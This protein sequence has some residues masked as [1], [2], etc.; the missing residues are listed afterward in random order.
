MTKTLNAHLLLTILTIITGA[1]YSFLKLIVP[2]YLQPYTVVMLRIGAGTLF[3]LLVSLLTHQSFFIERSDRW[4]LVA[5]SLCGV[6]LN[7]VFFYKGMQIT[8]PING[9]I[10]N[11]INPITIF[12]FSAILLKDPI[13][14]KTWIGLLLALGGALFLMDLGQFHVSESTFLGDVYVFINA[15][16]FGL[17]MVIVSPLVRKYNAFV[18]AFWTFLIALPCI[19]S[20]GYIPTM[21]AD[22]GALPALGWWVL[23]YII[24]GT[25]IVVYGINF[26][27]PTIASTQVF[28]IYVYLQPFVAA[29]V[30]IWV[31]NDTLNLRKIISGVIII[32]GIYIVQSTKSNAPTHEENKQ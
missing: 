19:V 25:T 7:Q 32:A 28:G 11:L 24:L 5:A 4:K 29:L 17:Y 27:I 16:V 26:Y 9:A 14:G 18:V 10:V 13:K 12:V 15:F 2:L 31:G 6:L 21:E 3:F 30:S 22:W 8:T 20:L 1:N 23:V